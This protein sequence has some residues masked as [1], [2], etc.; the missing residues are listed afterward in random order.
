MVLVRVLTFDV[1]ESCE[2]ADNSRALALR[3]MLHSSENVET[4][5]VVV[6]LL[7]VFDSGNRVA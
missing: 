7:I 3:K 5:L 6:N 4:R 2:A 1:N